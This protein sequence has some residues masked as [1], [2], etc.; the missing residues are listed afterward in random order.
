MECPLI[1]QATNRA[2]PSTDH[3]LVLET[4]AH[5]IFHGLYDDKNRAHVLHPL[6]E[7]LQAVPILVGSK[8]NR[9][10]SNCLRRG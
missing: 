3:Q 1:L 9:R 8:Y 5:L 2:C 7:G 10:L 4:R 6:V